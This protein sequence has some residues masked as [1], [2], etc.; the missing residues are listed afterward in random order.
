M[1]EPI[2]DLVE[3]IGLRPEHF[4]YLI[5]AV[6]VVGGIW[7]VIKLYQDLTGPVRDIYLT[8]EQDHD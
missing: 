3:T 2:Q 7:A 1:M 8:E 4:D 5:I 6:I